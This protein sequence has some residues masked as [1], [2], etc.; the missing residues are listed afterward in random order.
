V[1]PLSQLDYDEIKTITAILGK[2]NNIGA[3]RTEEV[4]SVI[5]WIC[6]NMVFKDDI[7]ENDN[8]DVVKMKRQS[9]ICRQMF[10]DKFGE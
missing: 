10:Q 9:N 4:I 5:F 8:E 2:C 1:V 3:G 6:C 7:L